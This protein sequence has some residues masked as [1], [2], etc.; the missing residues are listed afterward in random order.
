MFIY[1]MVESSPF[2]T[3]SSAVIHIGDKWNYFSYISL[4][5]LLKYGI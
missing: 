2:K 3:T 4:E 1:E 5:V